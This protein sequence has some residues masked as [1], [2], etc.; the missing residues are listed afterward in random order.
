MTSARLGNYLKQAGQ[1]IG[2]AVEAPYLV[3][4]PD[5]QTLEFSAHLPDFGADR[6][7]L[8]SSR[9]EDFAAQAGSLVA[10]GYGYSVLS[11]PTSAPAPEAITD[12]L[13]D[14]GWSSSRA[15]PEWLTEA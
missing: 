12:V 11:K 9:Y 13:K 6:G 4:L 5:G 14:W 10:A 8:L 1:L 7:M 15:C 3:V 2:F